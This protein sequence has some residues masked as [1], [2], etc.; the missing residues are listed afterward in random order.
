[1]RKFMLAALPYIIVV[2]LGAAAGSYNWRINYFE[3]SV[4]DTFFDSL[5]ELENMYHINKIGKLNQH[6]IVMFYT[7]ITGE[8]GRV[9]VLKELLLNKPDGC[10]ILIVVDSSHQE[11]DLRNARSIAGIEEEIVIVDKAL[12]L[13]WHNLARKQNPN[14]IYNAVG[15]FDGVGLL[16]LKKGTHFSKKRIFLK[17]SEALLQLLKLL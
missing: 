1:M 6:T 15:F 13:K 16:W 4:E 7:D 2:L 9:A 8:C 5:A 12:S 14:N 3:Y 17:N 10:H 11:R